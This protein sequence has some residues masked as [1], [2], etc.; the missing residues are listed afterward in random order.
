MALRQGLISTGISGTDGF[1]RSPGSRSCLR[2]TEVPGGSFHRPTEICSR[3][4]TLSSDLQQLCNA[5]CHA[6]VPTVMGRPGKYR[7]PAVGGQ[8]TVSG[9]QP[10]GSPSSLR[11]VRVHSELLGTLQPSEIRQQERRP[12]QGQAGF[13]SAHGQEGEVRQSTGLGVGQ[14][15]RCSSNSLVSAGREKASG[16]MAGT[17]TQTQSET[18]LTQERAAVW[19]AE[20]LVGA[21]AQ[22][23]AEHNPGHLSPWGTHCPHRTLGEKLFIT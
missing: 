13:C 15:F 16:N 18:H 9:G 10:S 11:S 2:V 17:P 22:V 8:D 1:S 12:M 6:M 23:G 14:G 20:H 7:H 4:R 19:L 5:G 3:L 21:A